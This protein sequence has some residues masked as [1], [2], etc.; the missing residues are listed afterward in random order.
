MPGWVGMNRDG[1]TERTSFQVFKYQEPGT[2]RVDVI[3]QHD[4]HRVLVNRSQER[5]THRLTFYVF[6]K[7]RIGT[8]YVWVAYRADPERCL[9]LKGGEEGLE[10]WE[11]VLEFWAPV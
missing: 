8:E 3:E 11:K 6:P 2:M 7:H 4:S 10:G 9:F 1:W 5:W